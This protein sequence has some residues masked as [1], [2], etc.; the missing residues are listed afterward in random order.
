MHGTDS[1]Q[2]FPILFHGRCQV[3]CCKL[4]KVFNSTALY[5]AGMLYSDKRGELQFMCVIYRPVY[6]MKIMFI[7]YELIQIDC[8][9]T[10]FA[11]S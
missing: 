8:V 5:L 3:K 10:E 6:T 7:E 11:L 1:L 4:D 2:W 9:N